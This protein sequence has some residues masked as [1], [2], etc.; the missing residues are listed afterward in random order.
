[1]VYLV[2]QPFAAGG[3]D[4]VSRFVWVVTGGTRYPRY[5]TPT[6]SF[7]RGLEQAIMRQDL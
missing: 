7:I 4:T 1:M 3:N 2:P 5:M 6:K